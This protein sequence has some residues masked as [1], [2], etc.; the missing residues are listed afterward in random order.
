[1]LL[2][3]VAVYSTDVEARV[4][5]SLSGGSVDRDTEIVRSLW[6]SFERRAWQEARSLF[7]NDA[8]LVWPV[9]REKISGADGI[10]KVQEIYPEGWTIVPLRISKLAD[11]QVLSIVR[12]DHPPNSFYA[13]SLFRISYGR[14]KWVEEYWSTVEEPP[15]WRTAGNIPGWNLENVQPSSH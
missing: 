11:D 13:V 9:S 3:A 15:A 6:Q 14:I 2:M 8:V 10:I 1:M 12:V 4:P 5:D 7:D